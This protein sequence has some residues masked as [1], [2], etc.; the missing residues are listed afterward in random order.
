MRNVL[1]AVTPDRSK[2]DFPR[3]KG[4]KEG[5]PLGKKKFRSLCEYEPC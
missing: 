1:R 3:L 5:G 4:E 2:W